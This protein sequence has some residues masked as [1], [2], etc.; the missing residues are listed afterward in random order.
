VAAVMLAAVM[1]SADTTL[2]TAGTI[3]SELVTGNLY[4][5]TSLKMT[6]IFIVLT[7]LIALGIAMKVTSILGV[8]M[9]SFSFFSGA[10]ILPIIAGISGW[11]VNRHL[12]WYAMIAGG[13]TALTGKII[14]E[15]F[16]LD[17]GYALIVSAYAINGAFLFFP[18][19]KK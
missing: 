6:R 14:Q 15:I 7:G 2:L 1:S 8:L 4:Q 9:L 16:Q 10:F 3:L 12:A 17:W 19:R 5:K 18:T 13:V 11:K